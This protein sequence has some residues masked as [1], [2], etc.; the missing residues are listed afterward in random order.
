M[1]GSVL[2]TWHRLAQN[3]ATTTGA[4]STPMASVRRPYQ[5][6]PDLTLADK[7]DHESGLKC[8]LKKMGSRRESD[9]LQKLYLLQINVCLNRR[10]G[11]VVSSRLSDYGELV[12]GATGSSQET[13]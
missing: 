1:T 13:R 2:R 6:G 8:Q 9:A 7:D 10:D 12:N 11:F 5:D 4:T 3:A